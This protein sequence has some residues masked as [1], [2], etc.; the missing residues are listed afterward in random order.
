MNQPPE[1]L[2]H[3]RRS[4][5]L[6][7]YD[8]SSD[9]SYFVTIC[10]H[11]REHL[12][13]EIINGMMQCSAAGEIVHDFCSTLHRRHPEI[14]ITY[15]VVMPNH[16]HAIID[17]V[18][19]VVGAIHPP[20]T[21]GVIHELPLRKNEFPPCESPHANETTHRSN[22]SPPPNNKSTRRRML[23]PLVIGYFKMISA[24][25]IN[26]LRDTPGFPV[27]QRNYYE[28]IITTEHE[29]DNIAEYIVTNPQNWQTD[30]ENV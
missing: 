1:S 28:H 4:I 7:G 27:W 2:P 9:G 26:L 11:E 15:A 18:N 30:S 23:L 29:Y 6:P 19:P 12:F 13:G 21:V 16:F 22:Q 17:I 24:K 14:E 5:R 20:P 25:Q 10:T 3:H 8:Y